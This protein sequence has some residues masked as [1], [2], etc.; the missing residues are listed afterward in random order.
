MNNRLCTLSD[1]SFLSSLS[2]KSQHNLEQ[3]GIYICARKSAT[4]VWYSVLLNIKGKMFYSKYVVRSVQTTTVLKDLFL[5]QAQ[6]CL[7]PWLC[8]LKWMKR[9]MTLFHDSFILLNMLADGHHTNEELT[10]WLW[11]QFSFTETTPN[12]KSHTLCMQERVLKNE[13]QLSKS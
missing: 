11:Y 12:F 8:S 3:Y 10:P 4:C 5:F 7:C 13:Q 9:W 1:Q 2:W 6:P